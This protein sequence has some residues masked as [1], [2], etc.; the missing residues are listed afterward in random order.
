M[1]LSTEDKAI[2]NHVVVDAD[3]W[4]EHAL[5]TI[6]EDAVIAKIE[7][8]RSEYLEQKDLPDYKTRAEREALV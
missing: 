1:D 7:R 6:G 4:V 5:E 8:W 2:L 3:K